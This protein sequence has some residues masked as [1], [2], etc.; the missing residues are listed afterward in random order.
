VSLPVS[1]Q[2]YAT[3]CL[4]HRHALGSSNALTT[5]VLGNCATMLAHRHALAEPHTV[6]AAL[7][8]R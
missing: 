4:W 8:G 6:L 5:F 7:H 1:S 3:Q 2:A